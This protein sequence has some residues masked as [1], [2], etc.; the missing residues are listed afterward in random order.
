MKTLDQILEAK[1]EDTLTTLN[2]EANKAVI[3]LYM[4]ELDKL[5]DLCDDYTMQNSINNGF[6]ESV[7]LKCLS[8]I[9]D[10]EL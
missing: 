1:I 10:N 3:A 2:C 5:Y 7:L 8:I 4:E 6:E 9:Y